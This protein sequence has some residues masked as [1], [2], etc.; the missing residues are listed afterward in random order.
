MNGRVL[1]DSLTC[2]VDRAENTLKTHIKIEKTT[3]MR[4]KI[5]K[6]YCGGYKTVGRNNNVTK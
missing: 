1:S 2:R 4:I 6:N 3:E 5:V